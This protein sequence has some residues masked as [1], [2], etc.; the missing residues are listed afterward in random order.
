MN[1]DRDVGQHVDCSLDILIFITLSLL[2]NLELVV[3]I[4]ALVSSVAGV[5]FACV[6]V[7]GLIGVPKMCCLQI[8]LCGTTNR[9]ITRYKLSVP[10]DELLT[11]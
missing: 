7:T 11:L 6:C 8:S 4:K 3:S 1:Y 2:S 10:F 9:A 5:R